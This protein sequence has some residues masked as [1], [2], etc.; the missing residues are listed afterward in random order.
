MVSSG[1]SIS[2]SCSRHVARDLVG[3]EHGQLV[4]QAAKAVGAGVLAAHQ[5]ELVLHQRVVDAGGLG[6]GSRSWGWV[7]PSSLGGGLFFREG[8]WPP[9][10]ANAVPAAAH[11]ATTR[12]A[13]AIGDGPDSQRRLPKMPPSTPRMISRPTVVPMVRTADL[14]M[15]SAR[16]SWRPPRG[17]V[18]PNT[19][20]PRPPSMPPPPICAGAAPVFAAPDAARARP[21]CGP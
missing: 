9:V 16:P 5:G 7:G 11:C 10:H 13:R 17:P 18:E 12:P 21:R 19:A 8:N 20:S 15:D 2:M 1:V 3:H 14:I 4:E 6:R